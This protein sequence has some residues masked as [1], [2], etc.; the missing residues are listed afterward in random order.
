[1][2]TNDTYTPSYDEIDVASHISSTLNTKIQMRSAEEFKAARDARSLDALKVKDNQIQLLTEQNNTLLN[3]INKMED[4]FTTLQ[5][6][7]LNIQE[8]QESTIQ[9]ITELNIKLKASESHIKRITIDY[10][11]KEKQLILLSNQNSELLRSLEHQENE[12]LILQETLHN[13]TNDTSTINQ[14]YTQLCTQY[15]TLEESS[16]QTITDN[17]LKTEEIR[18]LKVETEQLRNINNTIKNKIECEIENL[19]EQLRIRKEKQYHLLEKVNISEEAKRHAEDKVYNLEENIR[20][21]YITI[22][23]IVLGMPHTIH[24]S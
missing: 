19:N 17:N 16:K 11:E 22:E 2:S 20:Y 7:R 9:N 1:M 12:Q 13:L 8:Q 23:Y 3:T 5:M 24:A 14:R 10:S 6:E 18:L 21:V 4:D 15:K